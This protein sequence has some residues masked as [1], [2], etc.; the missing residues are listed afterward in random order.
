MEKTCNHEGG[1]HDNI[2]HLI[3]RLFSEPTRSTTGSFQSHQQST[4]ENIQNTLFRVI[5]VADL[6]SK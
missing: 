6:K 4:E 2:E 1:V 3:N 5:F